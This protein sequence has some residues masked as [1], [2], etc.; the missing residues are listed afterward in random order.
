MEMRSA[1]FWDST[2]RRIVD[3]VQT[4]RDISVPSS[5]VKRAKNS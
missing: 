5:R 2:R 4:F 1:L 3:T